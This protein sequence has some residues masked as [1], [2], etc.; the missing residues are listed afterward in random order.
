LK[1]K[2]SHLHPHTASNSFIPHGSTLSLDKDKMSIDSL[3][4][5]ND[6]RPVPSN[7]NQ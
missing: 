3:D 4:I 1:K 2:Q 7:N 6:R 5:S